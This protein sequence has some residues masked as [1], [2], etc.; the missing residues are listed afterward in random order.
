MFN[1]SGVLYALGDGDTTLASS[2][3]SIEV[4][5]FLFEENTGGN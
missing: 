4:K 3:W 2:K 1:A 5:A